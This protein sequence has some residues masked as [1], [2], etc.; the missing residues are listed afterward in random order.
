MDSTCAIAI[1]TSGRIGSVALGRD[2]VCVG[3]REFSADMQHARELV[4]TLARLCEEH[5]WSPAQASECY[6]SIGPGS[7]TGLRVGVAF[8]RHLALLSDLRICAVPSLAV[9]AANC[10]RLEAPPERVA[11]LLD[12]KKRQIFAAVY[13]REGGDY[14]CEREAHLTTPAEL[15]TACASPLAVMGDGVD[16]HRG[17]IESAGAAVVDPALWRPRAE[18]VLLLGHAMA[19][20]GEF[21]PARELMPVYIRRPEAEEVWERRHGL[22]PGKAPPP[23]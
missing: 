16:R 12:A 6:L 21:T 5:G 3:A 7:F 17:A 13:S 18:E 23:Q 9:I 8:A 19:Q 14:R 10:L 22:E 20:R 11:V 2:G 1:E 4:P 15:F